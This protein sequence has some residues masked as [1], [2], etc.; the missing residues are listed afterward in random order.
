MYIQRVA[1]VQSFIHFSAEAIEGISKGK[2]SDNTQASFGIIIYL[3]SSALILKL[4]FFCIELKYP[5]VVSS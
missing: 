2:V 3:I 4:F 5:L 1:E